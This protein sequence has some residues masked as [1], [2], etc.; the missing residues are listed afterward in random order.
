MIFTINSDDEIEK[1]VDEEVEEPGPTYKQSK[2]SK[3]E[4]VMRFEFDEGRMEQTLDRK[5]KI[6]LTMYPIPTVTWARTMS[7]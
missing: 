2:R 1:E 5:K 4:P 6:C 3:K 7:K